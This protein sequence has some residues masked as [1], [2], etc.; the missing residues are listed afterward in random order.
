MLARGLINRRLFGN[1]VLILL[2][3]CLIMRVLSGRVPPS[4]PAQCPVLP[5]P[6]VQPGLC[7]AAQ[8]KEMKK[9]QRE[10]WI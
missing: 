4:T 3:F 5:R 1:A 8:W 10:Q 6:S 9:G 7:L 2:S